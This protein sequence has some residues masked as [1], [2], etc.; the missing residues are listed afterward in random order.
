MGRNKNRVPTK[1]RMPAQ[2]Y[3]IKQ[4]KACSVHDAGQPELIALWPNKLMIKWAP[5]KNRRQK[6][7]LITR[8]GRME[9]LTIHRMCE[10]FMATFVFIRVL[11]FIWLTFWGP[12]PG[13]IL[14]MSQLQ[15]PPFEV[16]LDNYRCRFCSFVGRI[17]FQGMSESLAL[18]IQ[19]CILLSPRCVC[20]CI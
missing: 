7:M 9:A 4:T 18:R 1:M 6:A 8:S 5:D 3:H 19:V 12:S 16:Q 17:F 14:S 13:D 2:T 10:S 20:V 11:T 15:Q